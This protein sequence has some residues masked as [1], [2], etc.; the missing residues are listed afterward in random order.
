MPLAV[1]ASS[2]ERCYVLDARLK[3]DKFAG[4]LLRS[5]EGTLKENTHKETFRKP[6]KKYRTRKKNT[7]EPTFYL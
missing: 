4:T 1:S 3:P 2:Q 7:H 6:H 5:G